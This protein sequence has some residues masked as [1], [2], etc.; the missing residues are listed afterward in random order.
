M[1]HLQKTVTRRAQYGKLIWIWIVRVPEPVWS[2]WR[3]E[4]SLAPGRNRTIPRVPGSY[5]SY[6]TDWVVRS[7]FIPSRIC[8]F[9]CLFLCLCVCVCVCVCGR[10]R[11]PIRIS[12][13]QRR[14]I[15]PI[16]LSSAICLYVIAGNNLLT[17]ISFV[18]FSGTG[19]LDGVR[20]I[21]RWWVSL[22]Y[23]TVR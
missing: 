11:N 19:S 18:S 7:P 16:L 21:A 15:A 22:F 6:C 13:S 3:K 23:L 12:A 17:E 1:L 8:M 2:L 4:I 10:L 20:I 5:P 9:V 14:S